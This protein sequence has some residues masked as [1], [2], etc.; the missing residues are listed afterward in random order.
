[1]ETYY[2]GSPERLV[3]DVNVFNA[4]EDSFGSEFYLHMPSTMKFVT[5]DKEETDQ[6]LFCYPPSDD[7][8]QPVLRCDIGNPLIAQ[9]T[10]RL[11]AIFE[12]KPDY[13]NNTITFL[14]EVN[15]TNPEKSDTI[16]DNHHQ[17]TINVKTKANL[18]LTA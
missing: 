17:M 13:F 2:Q 5:I 10:A 18:R 9:H 8:R 4:G 12:L 7:D 11:R 3:I 16:H 6:T 15:N 14:A 1:M